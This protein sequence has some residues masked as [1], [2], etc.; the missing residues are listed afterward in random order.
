MSKTFEIDDIVEAFIT[1]IMH[2]SPIPRS[3][4]LERL[5]SDFEETGEHLLEQKEILKEEFLTVLKQVEESRE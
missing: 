1:I 2:K 4:I 3:T 5:I